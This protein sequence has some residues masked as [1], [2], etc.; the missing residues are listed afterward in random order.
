MKVC[1]LTSVAAPY[2]IRLFELIAEKI[3]LCVLMHDAKEEYRNDDWK[4]M[5]SESFIVYKVGK[6]YKALIDSLAEE[7]DIFVDGMYLSL[8]GYY[9]NKAFKKK[10]KIS[11]MTA[12][13]GVA[14]NRGF[15]INGIMSFLMTRH[16]HFL[17]SSKITD[18]YYRYYKVD[19]K[20]ILYYR[21]TSLY[22]KDIVENRKLRE[23]KNEVRR[24]LGI[25]DRFILL[26]VGRP[27]RVKGFDILL[28]AYMKTGLTD[29]IDLYI[30][31]G[32]PQDDIRK[33]VEDNCLE[34]VRFFDVMSSEKLKLY[35]AA[36]DASI[37]CSRGDVWGLVVNE[38]LSF[39]HPMISSDM[40]MAGVHFAQFG[41]NPIICE[42]NAVDEYA[43]S[44]QKLFH[45]EGLRKA[46]ADQAFSL[47]EGY[48]LENS[49][50]DIFQ[51][52]S[53]L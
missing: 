48:T 49:A 7:Y 46:M 34:N 45:D 17:S 21:F 37:I 15:L 32:Q 11:V 40:C 31:G 20:K 14:R 9:G 43:E 35:Y 51:A 27:I 12:D 47:I 24:D 36:A 19:E 50:E 4:L 26:S 18:R 52:L 25:E 38:A 33:A 30:I 23:K 1:W 44:I 6:D 29:K 5:G 41:N 10:G 16:E 39:G 28:N 13:G 2:T 3:D 22:E 42:L 53:L 8:Y